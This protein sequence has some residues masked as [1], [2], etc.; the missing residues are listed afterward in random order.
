MSYIIIIIDVFACR[1]I[2]M[3]SLSWGQNFKVPI[4]TFIPLGYNIGEFSETY[5]RPFEFSQK[6]F[7]ISFM[8]LHNTFV[9]SQIHHML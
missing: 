7:F 3:V 5:V 8:K 4:C 2:P 9:M 6:T 1:P